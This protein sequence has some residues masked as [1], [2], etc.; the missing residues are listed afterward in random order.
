VCAGI[1]ES[2]LQLVL[3]EKIKAIFQDYKFKKALATEPLS[4][5]LA[6]EKGM[7]AQ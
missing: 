1:A 2:S 4:L 5:A 6:K 3:Y 7:C